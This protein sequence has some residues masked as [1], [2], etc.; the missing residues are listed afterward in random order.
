MVENN[1]NGREIRKHFIEVEKKYKAGLAPRSPLALEIES[2]T[3]L[4]RM[5][6][7]LADSGLYTPVRAALFNAEGSCAIFG[8][9]ILD[10]LPPVAEQRDKR[11]T[12]TQLG[13]GKQPRTG[14]AIGPHR[15]FSTVLA[16]R[17]ANFF[18]H[19]ISCSRA[20]P[21]TS[22]LTMCG[23]H[24]NEDMTLND[25]M[26]DASPLLVVN[27]FM[28]MDVVPTANWRKKATV[29]CLPLLSSG[30]KRLDEAGIGPGRLL[31][32]QVPNLRGR[33]GTLGPLRPLVP[34][35]RPLGPP[36]PGSRLAQTR[37]ADRRRPYQKS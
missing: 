26:A 16:C 2:K 23:P 7:D 27:W 13:A 9:S 1:K 31:F 19:H 30:L 4:A 5:L 17:L 14:P 25:I 18:N 20:G 33:P 3:L 10:Y 32:P 24:I 29:K 12:P 34:L 28:S 35:G 8:N 22:I 36:L 21:P 11:L 37:V 15:N 6:N